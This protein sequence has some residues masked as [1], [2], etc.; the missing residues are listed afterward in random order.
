MRG[1]RGLLVLVWFGV[2]LILL[3]GVSEAKEILCESHNNRY[4]FCETEVTG[5]VKVIKQLSDAPCIEGQT[6]GY[7]RYGVWVTNGCRARFEIQEHG[8]E[9]QVVKIS[10]ESEDKR[11]HY[12]PVGN[13]VVKEVKLIKQFSKNPCIQGHSWGF[14]E[15]GV[16][17]DKGCRGEFSVY[18]RTGRFRGNEYPG[19]PP[20]APIKRKEW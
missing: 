9:T 6:W 11:Y 3:D 20:S 13:N 18:K 16:W 19:Y 8:K 7:D 4:R 10:C 1:F 15:S 5:P 2:A 17:V 14:D 12:C